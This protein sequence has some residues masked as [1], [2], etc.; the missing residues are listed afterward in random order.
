[1]FIERCCLDLRTDDKLMTNDPTAHTQQH[2]CCTYIFPTDLHPHYEHSS[3]SPT[4]LLQHQHIVIVNSNCFMMSWLQFTSPRGMCPRLVL[5]RSFEKKKKNRNEG[6]TWDDETPNYKYLV[7]PKCN[8]LKQ[9]TSR[10]WLLGFPFN[11][12][13]EKNSALIRYW[14]V[15]VWS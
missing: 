15:L 14:L 7:P 5:S 6:L 4:C 12:V 9:P 2:Y 10:T 13:K 8:Q 1:M 3:I 11:K